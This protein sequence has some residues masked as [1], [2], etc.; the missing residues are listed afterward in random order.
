[1]ADKNYI[2][3]MREKVGHEGMIFVI[4][5][6]VLWNKERTKILLEQRADITE[7]WAF[8]SGFVE[9][10]ESPTQAIEREFLEETGLKVKVTR[11]LGLATKIFE[12]NSWGDA[13]EN[14]SIGFEVE[15]I[16]GEL[17]ADGDETLQAKFIPV[18]PEPTMFLP[19][20]QM[21]VHQVITENELSDR[22]WI[23]EVRFEASND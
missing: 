8:V 22:P 4:V 16:E 5:F 2:A 20:A 1:M 11:Q 17:M 18:A 19:E 14:I 12:K 21:T 3:R 7:G 13:Q 23:R 15:L 10:G 9:Y 6:G